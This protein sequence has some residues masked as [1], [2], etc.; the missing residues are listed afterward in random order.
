MISPN[1]GIGN[2]NLIYL[3][4]DVQQEQRSPTLLFGRLFK[5]EHNGEKLIWSY[6]LG[7]DIMAW[8]FHGRASDRQNFQGMLLL[9]FGL[10]L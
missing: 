4:L 2:M 8:Y 10:L 1:F 9:L 6:Y 5:K 7:S 3:G